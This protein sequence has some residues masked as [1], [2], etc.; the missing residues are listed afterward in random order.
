MTD[1]VKRVPRWARVLA[2]VCSFA[3]VVYLF[4]ALDIGAPQP[5][6]LGGGQIF[7]PEPAVGG[8]PL[9]V[10][11][12]ARPAFLNLGW[13]LLATSALLWLWDAATSE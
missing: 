3:G 7:I 11:R 12:S 5:L 2:P 9:A 1:R 4:F 13:I 8:R 6:N 10:V